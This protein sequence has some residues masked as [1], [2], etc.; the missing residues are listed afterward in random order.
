MNLG[1]P[2]QMRGRCRGMGLF[3]SCLIFFTLPPLL[4]QLK[5]FKEIAHAAVSVGMCNYS[6][7]LLINIGNLR[8]EAGLRIFSK[9]NAI[10][11]S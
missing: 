9:T 10:I 2:S 5:F 4:G 6:G 11:I 8:R 7:L 3:I 1:S